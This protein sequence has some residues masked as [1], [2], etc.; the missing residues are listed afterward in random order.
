MPAYHVP[1]QRTRLRVQA[2]TV[3]CFGTRN[4]YALASTVVT[5][6]DRWQAGIGSVKLHHS[7]R[8]F[9]LVKGSVGVQGGDTKTEAR[10]ARS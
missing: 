8:A 5:V 1:W 10:R 6:T 9:Y 2:V 4:R 3:A 7:S